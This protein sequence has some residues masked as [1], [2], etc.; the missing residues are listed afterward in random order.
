MSAWMREQLEYADTK[1]YLHNF[2]YDELEELYDLKTILQLLEISLQD[3]EDDN[4]IT[5]TIQI[6]N[7]MI[8]A[9]VDKNNAFLGLKID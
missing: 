9:I 7:K 4:Q 5:R 3:N 1:T 6:L 8:S 2:I